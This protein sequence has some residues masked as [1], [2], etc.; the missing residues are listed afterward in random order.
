LNHRGR[1]NT[2]GHRG[3]GWIGLTHKEHRDEA[4]R[5]IGRGRI[6]NIST[7]QFKKERQTKNKTQ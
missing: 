2:E 4:L 7:N 1:E 5:H 3:P 6:E